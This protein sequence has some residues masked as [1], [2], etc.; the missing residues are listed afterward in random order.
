MKKG[1][2]TKLVIIILVL[3]LLVS[4]AS[5]ARFVV[6]VKDTNNQPMKGVDVYVIACGITPTC[7]TSTSGTCTFMNIPKTC[8]N[9]KVYANGKQRWTG[10][11]TEYVRI[12]L[13]SRW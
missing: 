11:Y 1:L 4:T 13:S 10:K 12:T 2:L 3:G 7:I 8:K 5:A 9:I 6:Y